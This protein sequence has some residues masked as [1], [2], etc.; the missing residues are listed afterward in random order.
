MPRP[1]H[2][3]RDR[4]DASRRRR[5]A[6][7]CTRRHG[8]GVG[9]IRTPCRPVRRRGD[10]R[11]G[12]PH[13]AGSSLGVRERPNRRAVRAAPPP[14]CTAGRREAAITPSVAPPLTP[15]HAAGRRL[16]TSAVDGRAR[17]R[18][19]R[20]GRGRD[21]LARRD[22]WRVRPARIRGERRREPADR[23][24]DAVFVVANDSGPTPTPCTSTTSGRSSEPGSEHMS[25]MLWRG[26]W[27]AGQLVEPVTPWT[28][29]SICSMSAYVGVSPSAYTVS[30][31]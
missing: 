23:P 12:A 3:R 30:P 11:R 28:K 21:R 8:H 4:A 6:R 25:A 9:R 13:P 2:G 7:S 5:R 19:G 18:R 14:R 26:M 1:R 17:W 10:R 15:T 27:C 29:K 24:R 22:P 31:S 16:E 20:V